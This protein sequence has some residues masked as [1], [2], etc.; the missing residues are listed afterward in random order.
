MANRNHVFAVDEHYHCYNRGTDKRTIFEDAQDFEYFKKSLRAYNTTLVLGKL[1]LYDSE[2]SEKDKLV[3]ILSFCLLPNHY[4]IVLCE[5]VEHGISKFMQRVGVGY[6]MYFN[7][8]N[9]RSGGL[10]QGTYK[11]KHVESDQDLRQVISYVTY[12]NVVHNISDTSLFRSE[13]NENADIV[14]GLTSNGLI[15]SNMSEIADIIK[16]QRLSFKE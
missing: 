16:M 9:Q 15:P 8:K 14:R 1:R 12:N 7:E 5:K 2:V 10:F 11:S 3:E 6:T 4:H 13:L